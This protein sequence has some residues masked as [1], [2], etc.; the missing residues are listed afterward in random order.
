MTVYDNIKGICTERGLSIHEVEQ[1]AGLGYATI[2]H[3]QFSSPRLGT[4]AKVA[5]A[6]NVPIRMLINGT[7]DER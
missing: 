5:I 4:L 1:K 7:E 6:L 2:Y 3:W